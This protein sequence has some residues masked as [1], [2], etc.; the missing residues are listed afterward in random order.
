MTGYPQ[1][2]FW[3]PVTLAKALFRIITAA[4]NS[5]VMEGTI[6]RIRGP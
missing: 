3:I 4:Q 2:V 5:F 1:L 6:L